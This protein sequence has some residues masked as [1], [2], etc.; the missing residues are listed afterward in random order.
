M[1]DRP[2]TPLLDKVLYPADIRQLQK[3]QLPQ[4]A[5][6]LRAEMI[7]AHCTACPSP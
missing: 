5:D 2:E 1:S 6:E 7:S 3:A 4:L